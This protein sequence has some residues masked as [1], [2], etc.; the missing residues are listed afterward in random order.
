MKIFS[1]HSVFIKR[2]HICQIHV[3]IE[4]K[5]FFKRFQTH[6]MLLK[7]SNCFYARIRIKPGLHQVLQ[8]LPGSVVKL[9]ISATK[10]RSRS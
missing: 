9:K 1:L 6:F 8:H 3:E 4:E 7:I 2:C 5:A 10:F